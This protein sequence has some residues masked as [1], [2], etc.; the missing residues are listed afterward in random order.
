MTE[1]TFPCRMG[2]GREVFVARLSSRRLL[3][4]SMEPVF[5]QCDVAVT[6]V[7]TRFAAKPLSRPVVYVPTEGHG[8]GMHWP[9]CAAIGRGEGL[10]WN[11][12]HPYGWVLPTAPQFRSS[13]P[14]RP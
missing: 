6:E 9:V 7:G 10:A 13:T 11:R 4:G 5:V 2:C 3:D 14:A 8:H 1:E 12:A